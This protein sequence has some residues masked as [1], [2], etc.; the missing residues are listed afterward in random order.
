MGPLAQSAERSTVNRK[1]TGSS[2]VGT[3][4]LK[5]TQDP[6]AQSVERSTV[7]R[8]VAGSSPVRIEFR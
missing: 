3:E 5:T 6:L 4:I 1:V 2:P 8:K 7:N